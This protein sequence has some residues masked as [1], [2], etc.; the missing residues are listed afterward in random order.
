MCV[1]TS[2]LQFS[3]YL[4]F[5]CWWVFFVCPVVCICLLF[6][7]RVNSDNQKESFAFYRFLLDRHCCHRETPFL[8]CSVNSFFSLL[9]PSSPSSPPK[10]LEL[11]GCLP[12]CLTQTNEQTPKISIYHYAMC[13]YVR[14]LRS[15]S[16][17]WICVIRGPVGQDQ[18][19]TP[20]LRCVPQ[21]AAAAA[22]DS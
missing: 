14:L 5:Q 9:L 4:F 1:S 16:L 12:A 7:L 11:A 8:Y 15:N 10:T 21:S 18:T 3:Y 6:Y 22:D 2:S 13:T 19:V 17:L 20:A